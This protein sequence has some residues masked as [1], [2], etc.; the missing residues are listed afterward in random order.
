MLKKY[1]I[2]AVLF[3]F[4]AGSLFAYQP[5]AWNNGTYAPM[6]FSLSGGVASSQTEKSFNGKDMDFG[7][8]GFNLGLSIINFFNSY[9]GVGFDFTYANDGYGKTEKILSDDID[10]SM[11]HFTPLL[12]MKTYILPPSTFPLSV[13]V[14]LGAGMDFA[15]I[16]ER[17]NGDSDTKKS[18][19]LTGV[20]L[21]A[22][23]GAEFSFNNNT[24]IA[25]EGR[26]NWAYYVGSNNYDLSQAENFTAAVKLGIK[27]DYGYSFAY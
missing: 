10:L 2:S 22:G 24:F 27:F 3:L 19:I 20:A 15:K 5:T 6:E 1:L 4:C 26:Y 23:L 18:E 8:G 7:G 12:L 25:L 13:Y 11:E 9:F 16:Y 14:P 21:M 17:T